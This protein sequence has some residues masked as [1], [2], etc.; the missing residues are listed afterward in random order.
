VNPV[1]AEAV[2]GRSADLTVEFR[3]MAS[4][5]RFWVV[6][7]RE[8]ATAQART[9]RDVVEAVARTCTRFD[10]ESDLMRAN[11]AGK[12]RT[13]VAREC[14]DAL[15]AAYDAYV[16][17]DGLFDPRVLRTLTAYGYDMSLP[18]ADRSI[19]LPTAEAAPRRR[20]RRRWKPSFDEASL[21]VAVGPEPVDLGG[22]GKGLAMSWASS[23]LRDAGEAALVEAGGD[24]MAL[25][26]GPDGTGWMVGVESPSG[27]GDPAA[28]L[29]LVDR[30]CATSSIRL[31]SWT[32]G[33]T[34]VHHLVD[35]RT[36][37]SA[38]SDLV[39]VT[40]VGSDPAT[41]EVW[42]KSLFV[43]GRAGIRAAADDRGLAA[44]WIDA[45]GY[46]GVSRAMRPY[47]DWQ[48]SRV[49]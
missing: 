20:T 49:A 35:P 3:S 38:E 19:D 15:C 27:T 21:E 31:R 12:R 37:R 39:S 24:L 42:S 18:F 29:R 2:A 47:V 34:Q 6:A 32:A 5:V 46:V 22:I 17:T 30:A 7:P 45:R 1:S 14:F 16:A 36:G 48:V 13:V 40:V 44:L 23:Q 33:G 28:V 8:G 9:A 41:C 25:G 11:A 4:D 26:G 43:V 10:P